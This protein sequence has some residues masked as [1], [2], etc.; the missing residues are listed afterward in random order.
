MTG[1]RFATGAAAVMALGATLASAGQTPPSVAPAQTPQAKPY[2]SLFA[3]SGQIRPAPPAP[4]VV[5]PEREAAPKPRVVCGM[6]LIPA[7]PTVDPR[8]AVT[9]PQTATR[10]TILAVP[11]PMCR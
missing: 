9:P 11:P 7:D 4:R 2:E 5:V 6:T 10:Y 1:R 8:I 3:P